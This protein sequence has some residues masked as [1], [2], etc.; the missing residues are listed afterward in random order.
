[1]KKKPGFL[2]S[3]SRKFTFKWTHISISKKSCL[4]LR[5][6]AKLNAGKT[7]VAKGIAIKPIIGIAKS[8]AKLNTLTL[9][10]TKVEPITVIIINNKMTKLN[11]EQR[12]WKD[13]LL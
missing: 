8:F 3:Y 6:T 13:W 12:V 5:E 10:A 11:K 2:L 4:S 9:P 7:A 1:M